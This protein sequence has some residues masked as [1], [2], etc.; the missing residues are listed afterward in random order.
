MKLLLIGKNGQLGKEI[1]SEARKRDFEL[2]AYGR[3]DLDITDSEKLKAEIERVHPDVVVNVSAY[4]VVPDCELYP[5]E[6]FKVNSTAVK[7]LAVICKELDIIFVTYSTDYVFDG[8]KGGPYETEDVPNPLQVYGISKV[9]GEFAALNYS[10][11]TYV[12]R[13]CGVYGGESG[14]RSKNGNFI[15]NIL[16]QVGDKDEIEVASEQIVNPTYAVDLA[17]T[18]LDLLEKNPDYGIY[19]LASEGY[20]SWAEFAQAVLRLKNIPTKI[21]PVDKG[22]GES[23]P[24]RPLFSALSNGKAKALGIDMPSWEDA[25]KRYLETIQ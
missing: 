5:Q 22:G 3:E 21:I 10:Q 20:C 1:V 14:S 24:K 25:L 4:H 15:L 13:T 7:E 11:K 18:T 8:L 12:I 17:K 23:Y 16:K 6:A 9:A 19:H 2:F